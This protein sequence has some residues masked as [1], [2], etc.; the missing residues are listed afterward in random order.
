MRIMDERYGVMLLDDNEVSVRVY[1]LV[2]YQW[3][4]I[5]YVS[6]N[7]PLSKLE[8]I[9]HTEALSRELSEI[10]SSPYLHH[11]AEWKLCARNVGSE[12]VRTVQTITGLS[13]EYLNKVREQELI[14]K[15]MFME[16]W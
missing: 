8:S 10:F 11:I 6:K 7:L 2:N 16:M 4:L 14:S 5:H 13:I 3:K 9:P 1:T 15:G 12:L